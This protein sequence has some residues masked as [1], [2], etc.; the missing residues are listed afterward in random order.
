MA[1]GCYYKV[2]GIPKNASAA[3]IKKAYRKSALKYHPDKNP[4]DKQAEARFKEVAEAYEVLSDEKKKRI[5]DQYG[6]AGLKGNPSAGPSAGGANPFGAGGNPFG[7]GNSFGGNGGN[8]FFFNAGGTPNNYSS[9]NFGSGGFQPRNPHDIFSQFF[10]GSGSS[11]F[12]SDDSEDEIM[13][14]FGQMGGRAK[15]K[16]KRKDPPIHVDV[17]CSLEELYSGK[18]KKMRIERRRLQNGR[19]VSQAKILEIPVKAGWKAG[20]KVTYEKEGD[21]NVQGSVEPADVVF[22][23]REKK[24][25]EFKRQGNDLVYTKKLTLKEALLGPQFMVKTLQGRSVAVDCSRETVTT[26]TEKVIHGCGMPIS[27][28]PGQFGA[29]R[30]KFDISFPACPLNDRSRQLIREAL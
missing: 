1:N 9:F 20:T 16:S 25:S 28:K 24:H 30:V 23:I 2:L 6:E 4:N 22:T 19:L 21:E 8:T 15:G 11:A 29:L 27:N 18:V 10:G 3:A 12:S 7:A 14:S 5:Y 26:S 17:S 13:R